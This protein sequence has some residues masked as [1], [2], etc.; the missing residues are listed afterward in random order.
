MEEGSFRQRWG[1]FELGAGK[2]PRDDGVL[3]LWGLPPWE[4]EENPTGL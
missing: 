3:S 1:G 2:S 4:A